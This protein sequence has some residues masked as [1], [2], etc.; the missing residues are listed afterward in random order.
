MKDKINIISNFN[1]HNIWSLL[2][3]NKNFRFENFSYLEIIKVLSSK[4][5][6]K[7]SCIFLFNVEPYEPRF[8]K[9]IAQLLKKNFYSSIIIPLN[10][11]NIDNLVKKIDKNTSKINDKIKILEKSYIQN[12]QNI[13]NQILLNFSNLVLE[14]NGTFF[15]N[16][17]W[18]LTRSPFTKKFELFLADKISNIIE[19]QTHRRKKAVFVDLDDTIW[20]GTIGEVGYNKIL[21]GEENPIGAA[22]SN[23]QKA[24]KKISDTGIILGIISKNYEKV[25]LTGFKNKKMILSKKDF[26]GWEINFNRK[27]DNIKTLC[28]KL[29]IGTNTVV[30]IDNSYFE[31]REV[32][33]ALPDVKVLDLPE[34]PYDYYKII[35]NETSLAYLSLSKEDILRKKSYE[36]MSHKNKEISQDDWLLSLKMHCTIKKLDLEN[37]DRFAQMQ[38]RINQINLSSR[39]LSLQ[40]IKK[41][42]NKKNIKIYLF[43]INDKYSSLGVVASITLREDKEK[44]EVI[45]FLMSCRALGRN[46][47][48]NI[49]NFVKKNCDNNKKIIIKFIKSEKNKLCR[50]ILKNNLVE[51]E[52]NIFQFDLSKKDNVFFKN[53]FI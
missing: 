8:L 51:I 3:E 22:H 6:K 49:F 33:L 10:I 53:T 20:G 16:K 52:K 1:T 38:Q 21:V 45:D 36:I 14:Y 2:S 17:M 27:S 11:E 34:E 28:K 42:N 9:L 26:A 12:L 37:L 5:F 29:N 50:E 39:R 4:K 15:S 41:E 43:S 46:L 24:L 30:F 48:N 44:I 7:S 35:L 13:N 47:E 23:L 19:L 32:K 40:Q 25:A 18:F 31:R